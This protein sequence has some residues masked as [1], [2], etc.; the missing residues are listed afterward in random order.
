MADVIIEETKISQTTYSYNAYLMV[1][2]VSI[3]NEDE[4]IVQ[5]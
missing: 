3:T 2:W 5:R 1:H 4:K